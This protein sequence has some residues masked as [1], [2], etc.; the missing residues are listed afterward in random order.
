[1]YPKKITHS[2]KSSG[3]GSVRKLVFKAR[4]PENTRHGIR[5]Y[6]RNELTNTWGC[7][8]LPDG[9]QDLER[10]W[11]GVDIFWEDK[12]DCM[13]TRERVTPLAA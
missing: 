2:Y 8:N 1:M 3:R 11:T 10:T 6:Y 12:Y 4:E 7:L 13:P 5:V 9:W